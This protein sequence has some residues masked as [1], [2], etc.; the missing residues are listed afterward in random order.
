MSNT[1]DHTFLSPE[2]L[3]RSLTT[4]VY[5]FLGL[6]SLLFIYARFSLGHVRDIRLGS[7]GDPLGL[8]EVMGAVTV[9]CGLVSVFLAL[10]WTYRVSRNA[11][12]FA[13]G[14]EVSP[15][16]A[17]VWYFVPIACL[18]KPFQAL[19]EAW[20][21]SAD[22]KAWRN[23]A[24]PGVMR[25]WWGVWLALIVLNELN[26]RLNAALQR[27]LP[28]SAA[29]AVM[30]LVTSLCLVSAGQFFITIVRR[31]TRMQ[32]A[33]VPASEAVAEAG[34]SPAA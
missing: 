24:T 21:A 12:S 15:T 25:W 28:E 33:H 18:W 3:S 31:L 6:L 32:M 22:P 11:H 23:V 4:S 13:E 16:G 34:L 26:E 10:K 30:E 19:S 7:P 2:G 9:F 5:V 27:R 17:V 8:Y 20:R 14:L 1:S 29:T